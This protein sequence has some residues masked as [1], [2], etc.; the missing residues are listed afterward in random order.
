MDEDDEGARGTVPPERR[1]YPRHGVTLTG[2]CAI[3][4]SGDATCQVIDMSVGGAALRT[5]VA[6][7]VGAPIIV[8][9]PQVGLVRGRVA[10]PI[11]GGLAMTFD[12]GRAQ[13]ECITGFL[14]WLMARRLDAG[15][16]DRTF[17]RVVPFH[18]LVEIAFG[19]GPSTNA[20]IVDVSRS[21]VALTTTASAIPGDAMRVGGTDAVVVRLS[22]G[23][24]AARFL[25][26]LGADFDASVIL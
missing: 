24:L 10:R 2:V 19:E 9:L 22:A 12:E 26:P 21:G 17:E 20:R 23:G 11:S 18:R 13:R 1:A 7:P 25:E 15:L 5:E 3:S 4:E 16:E 14:T 6:A 8:S